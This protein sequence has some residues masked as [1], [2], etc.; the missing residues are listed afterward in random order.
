MNFQTENST[1][2]A[3][4][5]NGVSLRFD[6]S[7]DGITRADWYMTM[8]KDGINLQGIEMSLP[9]VSAEYFTQDYGQSSNVDDV[10]GLRSGSDY[11]FELTNGWYLHICSA[12]DEGVS[13]DFYFT[14]GSDV[15]DGQC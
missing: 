7:S 9:D 6:L 3:T 8:S 10:L 1:F 4:D 5:I 11:W 15:F 12:H 14:I 13:R 2:V